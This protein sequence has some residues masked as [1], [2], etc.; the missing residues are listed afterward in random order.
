M[1]EL[2][3][4]AQ[5]GW[6][7]KGDRV[8]DCLWRTCSESIHCSSLPDSLCQVRPYRLWCLYCEHACHY[9][10][11]WPSRLWAGARALPLTCN[12]RATSPS[13]LGHNH[14]CMIMC[15]VRVNLLNAFD[16]TTGQ[17][18]WARSFGSWAVGGQAYHNGTGA[19]PR[20]AGRLLKCHE[21]HARLRPACAASG[22]ASTHCLRSCGSRSVS[23][24]PLSNLPP[25]LIPCTPVQCSRPG[26]TPSGH[27]T[28]RLVPRSGG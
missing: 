21:Y 16:K 11:A 3:R 23:C 13:S 19:W 2:K 14:V 28:R 22:W 20:Q 10:L 8:L 5:G 7:S 27:W 12:L 4:R 18:A 25:A 6:G 26:T 9:L 24:G 15:P 1:R 17:S